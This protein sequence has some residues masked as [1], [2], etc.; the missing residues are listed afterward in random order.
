MTDPSNPQTTQILILVA[1]VFVVIFLLR[2]L[3]RIGMFVLLAA[4]AVAAYVYFSGRPSAAPFV[5]S[6]VEL[7][8]RLE[9]PSQ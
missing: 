4:A 2:M 9:P 8:A 7:G 3:R 6:A 5:E 1:A